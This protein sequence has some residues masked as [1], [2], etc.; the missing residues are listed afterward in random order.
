MSTAHVPPPETT[1]PGQVQAP[2]RRSASLERARRALLR[3]D[4]KGRLGR[5]VD[6]LVAL[7]EIPG[8]D[9]RDWLRRV[10]L[11]ERDIVLP[12]KAALIVMLLYSF[13]S[14][15][16]IG[17]V[18]SEVEISVEWTRQFLW[19]YTGV[20]VVVG[21]CLLAVRR[22]PL[23]LIQWLVFAGSLVD[24]IFLSTLLVLTGGFQSFLYWLFLAL[25]VRS[26]VSVPRATS[27][28]VLNFTLIGCFVMAGVTHLSISNKLD[29][30]A[31]IQQASTG[32]KSA[33]QRTPGMRRNAVGAQPTAGE[34]NASSPTEPPTPGE[35]AVGSSGGDSVREASPQESPAE[36]LL[37]RLVLLILMTVCSYGV[38]VLFQRQ[39]QAIEE[40][41]EFAVREVQLHAAGRLAAQFAHQIKNPLAIINTAAYSLQRAVGS[42]AEAAAQID[43]IKE[44]VE[45]AD[46]IITEVMG[47]AQ[48]S[49]GHVEKLDVV[50]ELDRAIERVFP[51]AAAFPVEVVR[52]YPGPF[53]PLVMLRSHASETFI[54]VLQNA[55]E[56][57]T[58]RGG[59][60]VVSGRWLDDYSIEVAITDNGRG[61]PPEKLER[62][63]EAYYTTKEKGTGLG[64]ATVKHN[65]GL[66]G[67][68]VRVE[69]ELGKGARFILLFPAKTLMNLA[70]TT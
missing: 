42:K 47:Y 46:R 66:Y 17:R 63:F 62:V 23:G 69:S 38:Q 67:G 48:L 25:V 13:Y 45:H 60:V 15:P 59:K 65:V 9:S 22:L 18:Q 14:S 40:A 37:V 2:S 51:P 11:M 10:T 35:P 44:E 1:R 52:D 7:L 34:T 56:A 58:D 54:N 5:V 31:S 68:T 12:I 4:A 50:E 24:G 36:P 16:W 70:K 55:R 19:V 8:P 53:P 27:Q 20:N 6:W 49:E 57:L 30:A 21:A 64:L 28:L 26:A 41:R 43:M 33:R 3:A 39:R 29:E 61:I 32:Q